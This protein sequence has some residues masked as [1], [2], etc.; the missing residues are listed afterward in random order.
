MRYRFALTNGKDKLK[1]KT[2][3][4]TTFELTNKNKQT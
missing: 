1:I 3:S 4:F 2:K